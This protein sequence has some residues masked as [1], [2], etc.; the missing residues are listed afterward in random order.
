MFRPP[1][2]NQV[3]LPQS[4][5]LY[6]CPSQGFLMSRKNSAVAKFSKFDFESKIDNYVSEMV[7]ARQTSFPPR[8]K[9]RACISNH[10][11]QWPWSL[12]RRV[13]CR[14]S[15]QSL[16]VCRRPCMYA[17]CLIVLPNDAV[18]CNP[19]AL[20]KITTAAGKVTSIME[21]AASSLRLRTM[22]FGH[23]ECRSWRYTATF[24]PTI[25]LVTLFRG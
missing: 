6:T 23:S 3:A 22:I 20:Q 18:T 15:A 11:R 5:H 8:V 17:P 19:G 2:F 25:S 21:H 13:R 10:Q 4:G 7:S 12:P 9:S 24:S 14:P 1:H 16:L